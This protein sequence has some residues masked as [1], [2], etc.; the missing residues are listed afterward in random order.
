MNYQINIFSLGIQAA[1]LYPTNKA[2]TNKYILEDS[3]ANILVVE[4]EK[5]V[6]DIQPYWKHLPH[7]KKIIVWGEKISHDL[8]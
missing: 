7:L 4:H 1:G 8:Y 2:E 5:T 3:R 6:K